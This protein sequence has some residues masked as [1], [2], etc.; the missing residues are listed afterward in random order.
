M[1]SAVD[2]SFYWN[3]LHQIISWNLKS[4]Y[5]LGKIPSCRHSRQWLAPRGSCRPATCIG[6]RRYGRPR[7]PC[8]SC[9]RWRSFHFPWCGHRPPPAALGDCICLTSVEKVRKQECQGDIFEV[10]LTFDM[11]TVRAQQHSFST[12]KRMF[13]WKC[14]SFWDRKCFDLRGTRTPNLWIHAECSNHLSSQGQ[15]FALLCF[16]TLTLAV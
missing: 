6:P 4:S 5:L 15:T 16:W 8:C 7:N 12:H 2:I 14:Q 9:I 1:L 11:L 3:S 10:K 13:F